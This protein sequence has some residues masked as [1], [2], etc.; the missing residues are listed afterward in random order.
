MKI[1]PEK[2]LGNTTQF[3]TIY[4][5]QLYIVSKQGDLVAANP[6][7]L[8]ETGRIENFNKV[9]ADGHAF[10]GINEELGLVSTTKGVF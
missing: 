10:C 6:S 1:N 5:E 7:T 8:K 4:N 3:A 2:E 9:A